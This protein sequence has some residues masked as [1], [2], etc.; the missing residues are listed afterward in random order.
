MPEGTRTV[1]PKPKM[2]LIVF[3]NV[4]KI[5]NLYLGWEETQYPY[6]QDKIKIN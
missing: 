1:L 4:H 6:H 2:P 5:D 3:W